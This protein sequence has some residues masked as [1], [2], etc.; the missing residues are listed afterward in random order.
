MSVGT[1]LYV[2]GSGGGLGQVVGAMVGRTA[3]FV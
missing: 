2:G 1:T 3:V